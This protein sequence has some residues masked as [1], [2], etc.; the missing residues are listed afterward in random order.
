MIMTPSGITI[1]PQRDTG[2]NGNPHWVDQTPIANAVFALN[3]PVE[4]AG[5]RGNVYT[6]TGSVF[7]PRGSDLQDGDRITHQSKRFRVIGDPQWDMNQP[8][9]GSDFGYVEYTIRMGG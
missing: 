1:T 3:T 2:S 6:Q 8:F 5:E 7:V 9:T 4:Q